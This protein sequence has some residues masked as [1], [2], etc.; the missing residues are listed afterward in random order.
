VL[1]FTPELEGLR[2]TRGDAAVDPLIARERREVFSIHPEVRIAAWA[3]ALLLA[4]AIGLFVKNNFELFDKRFIAGALAVLAAACYA[5][6]WRRERGGINEY[7]VLLGALILSADVA[8]IEQQFDVFGDQGQRHFLVLAVLHGVAAYAFGS[9][10]VL[11]LSIAALAAWMGLE[12]LDPFAFDSQVAMSAFV[13]AATLLAWRALDRRFRRRTLVGPQTVVGPQT[14]F[15]RVF[16]HFAS[17]LALLGGLALA[18]EEEP[19]MT[20]VVTVVLAAVVIAW[21]FRTKAESFVLYA[22]VYAVIAIDLYFISRAPDAVD[23]VILATTLVAV[24]ALVMI[25]R[26][27]QR[28]AA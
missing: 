23:A 16:E 7:I 8:F 22:F 25:H 4:G 5:W 17:H 2:I 18:P 28:S 12:R 6:A 27:F 21:G 19:L 15:S 13:C 24:P 10:L 11:S 1:D 20:C 26:R 9:K 14:E 3:G